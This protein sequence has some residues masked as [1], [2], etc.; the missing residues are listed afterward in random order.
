MYR[1]P[2]AN[3]AYYNYILDQNDKVKMACEDMVLLGDLNFD[4]K[5]DESLSTNPIRYIEDLYGLRQLVTEP[6]RTTLTSCT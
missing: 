6:T 5:F 3:A 2:S 4:Y 1:P